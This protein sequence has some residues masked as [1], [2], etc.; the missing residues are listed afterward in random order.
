M[1]QFIAL[2]YQSIMIR[3][4]GGS[5]S[6]SANFFP[7]QFGQTEKVKSSDERS[8]EGLSDV[9]PIPLAPVPSIGSVASYNSHHKS[10]E[11]TPSILSLGVPLSLLGSA[12]VILNERA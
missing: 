10:L 9:G 2:V 5:C 8:L 3:N 11:A 4:S 1:Q 7:P 6:W 12:V